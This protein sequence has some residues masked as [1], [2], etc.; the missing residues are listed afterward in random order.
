M[1]PPTPSVEAVKWIS[2][3]KDPYIEPIGFTG[4][5]HYTY[6]GLFE[7]PVKPHSYSQS[8]VTAHTNYKSSKR[9]GAQHGR[10]ASS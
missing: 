6:V 2:S 10:N 9:Y 5:T 8:V 4:I 3:L 7:R 1:L